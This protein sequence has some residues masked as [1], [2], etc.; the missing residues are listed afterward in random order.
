M[1]DSLVAK[2]LVTC[3]HIT[4]MHTKCC[5]ASIFRKLMCTRMHSK[6]NSQLTTTLCLGESFIKG[7]VDTWLLWIDSLVPRL[8]FLS[9]Y[10]IL[11]LCP[12]YIEFLYQTKVQRKLLSCDRKL[13]LDG[14]CTHLHTTPVYVCT[15]LATRAHW[16]AEFSTYRKTPHS[17]D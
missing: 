14:G 7:E 10:S 11:R 1:E 4:I 9:A 16:T 12:M 17:D 3:V 13:L 15:A 8:S 6:T 2:S 5:C